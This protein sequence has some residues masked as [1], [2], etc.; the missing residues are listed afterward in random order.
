MDLHGNAVSLNVVGFKHFENLVMPQVGRVNLIAGKNNVG[1]SSLLEAIRILAS[2]CDPLALFDTLHERENAIDEGKIYQSLQDMFPQV[3]GVIRVGSETLEVIHSPFYKDGFPTTRDYRKQPDREG[4][5]WLALEK[6][7]LSVKFDI[8]SETRHAA[9]S[10]TYRVDAEILP[11]TIPCQES[12][13]L[14]RDPHRVKL[15][16]DK[17]QGLPA[18]EDLVAILRILEPRIARV[19]I[20]TTGNSA[21]PQLRLAGKNELEPLTRFGDGLTVLFNLGLA[22]V[23]ARAGFLLAD[24]IENG[25]HYTLFPQLWQFLLESCARLNVVMFATTHSQDAADSFSKAALANPQVEGILTRLEM[26]DG[27]VHAVQFT[28]EEA[29]IAAVDGLEVR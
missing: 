12:I 27:S 8:S 15:L 11:T 26:R 1:K 21:I 7:A 28:E 25:L 29:Y 20:P 23:N 19:V 2:G 10:G 4:G 6:P 9:Y 17:I 18:E 3:R 16:W 22:L 14:H 13:N 5:W 24:E